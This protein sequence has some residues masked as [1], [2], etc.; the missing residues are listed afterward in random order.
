[1]QTPWTK[2]VRTLEQARDFVLEVCNAHYRFTLT[3]RGADSW[4]GILMRSDRIA[5]LDFRLRSRKVRVNHIIDSEV[6]P[7]RRQAIGRCSRFKITRISPDPLFPLLC[8]RIDNVAHRHSYTIFTSTLVVR[9][10][11]HSGPDYV[12]KISPLPLGQPEAERYRVAPTTYHECCCGLSSDT[13]R[14][15]V[16]RG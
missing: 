6:D 15:N 4:P 2:S 1:M 5:K 3:F 13:W 10:P 7:G 11:R 16:Q 12:G 8:L 9:L 14:Y